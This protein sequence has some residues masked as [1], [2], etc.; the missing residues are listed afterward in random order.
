[1]KVVCH[2]ASSLQVVAG[3]RGFSGTIASGL[4][5]PSNGLPRRFLL[6]LPTY[7][8]VDELWVGVDGNATIAPFDPFPVATATP[9]VWYGTSILQVGG[10]E[11][12]E[13]SVTSAAP[14]HAR[15]RVPR[16][17]VHAS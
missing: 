9:I 10:G 11:G 6:H 1:V 14:I 2:P 15:R 7:N 13:G 4:L 5:P 17:I 16:S 8:N 3:Q 12:W